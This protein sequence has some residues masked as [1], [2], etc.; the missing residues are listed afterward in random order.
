MFIEYVIILSS[1]LAI[2]GHL[3][4]QYVLGICNANNLEANGNQCYINLLLATNVRDCVWSD[5]YCQWLLVLHG[6][7]DPLS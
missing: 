5:C 2:G 6:E 3:V 1:D 4:L 7:F